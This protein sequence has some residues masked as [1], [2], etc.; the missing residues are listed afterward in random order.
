[1]ALVIRIESALPSP[2]LPLMPIKLRCPICQRTFDAPEKY[3]GRTVNCPACKAAIA[4]PALAAEVVAAP[5]ATV[6]NDASSAVVA[7]TPLADHGETTLLTVRPAMFRNRPLR[8]LLLIG[9]IAIGG[10]LGWVRSP[11]GWIASVAGVAI[12][13]LWW[14]RNRAVSL[15]V[16]TKRTIMRNGMLARRTREVRHADV[17]F[18]EVKQS[19]GQ[20]LRGV[21]SLAISSAA[22]GEVE[23]AIN[24]IPRPEH[25]KDTIDGYRG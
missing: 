10:V 9:L 24:G 20:R 5:N 6:P 18:L 12:L 7:S 4:I 3:S 11:F 17:R 21:G 14:V 23:I 2:G 8:F 19:F 25:V 16:T 13:L 1:V 15:E 22:H